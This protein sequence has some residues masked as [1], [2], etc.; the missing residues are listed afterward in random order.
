MSARD[1]Y[2]ILHMQERGGSVESKK[3]LDEIDRLRAEVGPW[4]QLAGKVV[5]QTYPILPQ[6]DWPQDT[7]FV[8]FVIDGLARAVTGENFSN[9]KKESEKLVQLHTVIG[10]MTGRNF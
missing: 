2:P 10:K 8:A 4:R 1:E 6:P 9:E 7:A 3:A 5:M